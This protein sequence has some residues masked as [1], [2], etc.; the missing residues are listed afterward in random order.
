MIFF[1]PS[2]RHRSS[3]IGTILVLLLMVVSMTP[4]RAQSMPLQQLISM[5][6]EQLMQL[7]VTTASRQAEP[8]SE[9]PAHTVVISQQ[10]IQ[11]R[12][13]HN[14][15]D[16][17]EDQPG[18]LVQRANAPG[19]RFN[20][21]SWRG[22]RDN[23]HFQLML[24]GI[25]VDSPTGEPFAID[26]NFPLNHAKQVE[27]IY[28]P[29][30][31]LYGSDAAAGVINI[32]SKKEADHAR[33]SL[34][35][36]A[37]S[38]GNQRLSIE[39]SAPFASSSSLAISGQIQ[40]AD[41]ADLT[42]YYP[43]DF[44]AVDAKTFAGKVVVPAA[45]R[46]SFKAPIKNHTLYARL[47]LGHSFSLMAH[48]AYNRHSTAVGYKF[49]D[50]LYSDQA[51]WSTELTTLAAT[52]QW[53]INN[54]FS[55]RSEIHAHQHTIKPDSAFQNIFTDLNTYYK[56]G[57]S[58]GLGIDEQLHWQHDQHSTVVGVAFDALH[59]IPKTADL[60]TPYRTSRAPGNQGMLYAN[61]PLALRFFEIRYRTFGLFAQMKSRWSRA[62][63][64]TIGL[65]YDDDSRFGGS[66]N[67]RLALVYQFDPTVVT[68]LLYAE[69]FRSPSTMDMFENFGSFSGGKD[70][71]GRY[72][73]NFFHLPNQGLRPEKIRNIEWELDGP[74]GEEG[75]ANLSLFHY[76]IQ[77]LILT[78]SGGLNT[79]FIPGSA[80][81]N[82][83]INANVGSS[84]HYGVELSLNWHHSFSDGTQLKLWGNYSYLQGKITQPNGIKVD[85]PYVTNQ[86]GRLGLTFDYRQWFAL[87][88]RLRLV[89]R[90]NSP[91]ID[92]AHPSQRQQ[93]A[94]YGIVDLHLSS[95]RWHHLRV[96]ADVRNLLDRRYYHTGGLSVASMAKVPQ[97]PRSILVMV[98]STL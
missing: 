44:A 14:L 26:D 64:T 45:S 43:Q 65:R 81:A 62:L 29:A 17:L 32:I 18:F 8:L 48:R 83:E 25:R 15:L 10:Q 19:S 70:A 49:S 93:V 76:W 52:H 23:P 1:N 92:A 77:D 5:P 4:C 55:L 95:H 66:V 37:G 27:I 85:L 46:Q 91:K 39:A 51:H 2:S 56:Y 7:Q 72:T 54:T 33:A 24:D 41:T 6:M 75:V 35:A 36:E 79:S 31:S 67:P 34:Q 86:Q 40:Q 53:P 3:M 96:A 57:R 61:T 82:T 60:P 20:T 50:S 74:L 30:S 16:L 73:S 28:G 89:G 42:H 80:I 63:S 87:T 12:G 88:P 84:R 58:R 38:F 98:E 9:A 69:A 78:Q 68:K 90:S 22:L 94:G 71:S 59:S 97:A 13:Y 21:V 47:H 11:H